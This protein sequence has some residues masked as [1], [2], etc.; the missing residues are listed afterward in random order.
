MEFPFP[1]LISSIEVCSVGRLFV[2]WIV[3]SL[4]GIY[5]VDIRNFFIAF[6]ILK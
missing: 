3:E 1:P 5:L 4:L 6:F 2:G